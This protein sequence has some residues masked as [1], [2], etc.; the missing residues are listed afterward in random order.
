MQ[1]GL[2]SSLTFVSRLE[3]LWPPR[4]LEREDKKAKAAAKK[5][6]KAEEAAESKKAAKPAAG[7]RRKKRNS[8]HGGDDGSAESGD[9]EGGKPAKSSRLSRTRGQFEDTGPL[10]LVRGPSFPAMYRMGTLQSW[11][12]WLEEMMQNH[13][14]VLRLKK[15]TVKKVLTKS[16]NRSEPH[17]QA[18]DFIVQKSKAFGMLQSSLSSDLKKAAA[19]GPVRKNKTVPQPKEAYMFLAFDLLL[20]SK[21]AATGG[22]AD[23]DA[24][25]SVEKPQPW[26]MCREKLVEKVKSM[27]SLSLMD[28]SSIQS[29]YTE[30]L[31]NHTLLF[32]AGDGGGLVDFFPSYGFKRQNCTKPAW[33]K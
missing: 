33:L 26:L 5:K 21:L 1:P 9:A 24:D 4:E 19:S 8:T 6:R 23:G 7:G 31:Q 27:M 32:S 22:D 15:G 10:V 11:K 30:S 29:H 2:S 3:S 17:D 16:L 12:P 20:K 18:K 25:K 28:L 14:A 13:P